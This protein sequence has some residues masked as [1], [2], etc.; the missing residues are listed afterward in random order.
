[1]TVSGHRDDHVI[2]RR[3]RLEGK[4]AIVFRGEL[5]KRSALCVLDDDL[6]A[7]GLCPAREVN[8][9]GDAGTFGEGNDI[10]LVG[11]S[12]CS[13]HREGEQNDIQSNA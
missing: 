10:E 8:L 1:V 7:S 9:S 3:R 13:D 6:Y 5:G 4:A 11:C 12:G 2:R